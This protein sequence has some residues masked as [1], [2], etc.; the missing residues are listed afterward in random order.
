M[1]LPSGVSEDMLT[2]LTTNIEHQIPPF[3]VD[4]PPKVPSEKYM[5]AIPTLDD[6]DRDSEDW[7]S[8]PMS[9]MVK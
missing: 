4:G 1:Y 7:P 5:N 3:G 2:W 6:T 8:S 9:S